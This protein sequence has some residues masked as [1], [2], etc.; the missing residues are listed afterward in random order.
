M[1]LQ[2]GYTYNTRR[3]TSS[4][5]LIATAALPATA[6][7]SAPSL[8]SKMASST[9]ERPFQL[10]H[11]VASKTYLDSPIRTLCE[12]VKDPGA[13]FISIHDLMEAYNILSTRIRTILNQDTCI[14]GL[15]IPSLAGIAEFSSEIMHCI[16]RDIQR[17]LPSPF[18]SQP[19][20]D[21]SSY[22]YYDAS[23]DLGDI[24]MTTDNI[25]LC[26]YAL[27]FASD[28]FAFSMLYSIFS[29]DV[30]IS[31]LRGALSLCTTTCSPMVNLDKARAMVVWMLKTQQLPTPILF[32]LK[33]DIFATVKYAMNCSTD[34]STIKVDA[35][36]AIYALTKEHPILADSLVDLLDPLLVYLTSK[37]LD[38]RIH[39]SLALCGFAIAKLKSEDGSSYPRTKTTTIACEYI[40]RETKRSKILDPNQ[41]LPNILK[42]ALAG[43]EFW[44]EY[45]PS[46]S[47]AVV[48]SFI[49]LI[50]RFIWKT[51]RSLKLLVNTIALFAGHRRS[52][53]RKAHPEL[54]RMLI[55]AF[56]RLPAGT[57]PSNS[58][59]SGDADSLQSVRDS[60]YNFLL[61]E[62]KHGLLINVVGSLLSPCNGE[63][64]SHVDVKKAVGNVL[65]LIT[66]DDVPPRDDGMKLLGRM[67]VDI[68]RPPHS[69]GEGE[70]DQSPT[71][72][73]SW[74]LIDGSAAN[75]IA[76][77]LR[78]LPFKL[79]F[80]QIPP[81]T[82]EEIVAHWD[83]LYALWAAAARKYR[84]REPE[85][86]ILAA[87]LAAW[88][89]LLLARGE[90][91]P[92]QHHFSASPAVTAGISSIL[93]ELASAASPDTTPGAH[94][95]G[96]AFVRKLWGVTRNVFTSDWLAGLAQMLLVALLEQSVGGADASGDES[97]GA[98]CTELVATGAPGV[99]H[100]LE[101]RAVTDAGRD[102]ARRLWLA[103]ARG[104]HF[105]GKGVECGD[106]LQFLAIPIGAWDMSPVEFEVWE[107]V[108]DSAGKIS[109][110]DERDVVSQLVTMLP[111]AKRESLTA[112]LRT[113]YA[114][115]S[116]SF[117]ASASQIDQRLLVLVDA[118]LRRCYPAMNSD[119][120]E[121]EAER[122]EDVLRLL[123]ALGA[124]LVTTTPAEVVSFLSTMQDSLTCWVADEREILQ[125]DLHDEIVASLYKGPLALLSQVEPSI[126][127]LVKIADF[128]AAVFRHIRGDGALAF[129]A[130]WRATYHA[131]ADIPKDAYPASI[132]AC[133]RAWSIFCDDSLGDGVVESQSQ[134]QS[135]GDSTVPGSQL[136]ESMVF[137]DEAYIQE[138][139]AIFAAE[140]AAAAG[141]HPSPR[142]VSLPQLGSAQT[143][144]TSVKDSDAID[145]FDD[146]SSRYNANDVQDI[147]TGSQVPLQE[148]SATSSK[149]PSQDS[150]TPPNAKRRR[151]DA[152][153]T[154]F[155]S[156]T[157]KERRREAPPSSS[158]KSAASMLLS[159][160]SE[161]ASRAASPRARQ[162]ASQPSQAIRGCDT[163]GKASWLAD[164]TDLSGHRS[165]VEDEHG[166]RALRTSD[167]EMRSS[168][169]FDTWEQ[170]ISAED[171]RDVRGEEGEDSDFFAPDSEENHPGPASGHDAS[172]DDVLESLSLGQYP[173]RSRI[174]Y[175]SQTAPEPGDTMDVATDMR[176][177]HPLRREQTSPGP[178]RGATT[179]AA[180]LDALRNAYAAL[181]DTEGMSQDDV[182]EILQAR[183]LARRIDQVLDERIFSKITSSASRPRTP[184]E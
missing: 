181:A 122:K 166:S 22:V 147:G 127:T 35:L 170:G 48:A 101:V 10:S 44:A 105:G 144:D 123:R 46:F 93:V 163:G 153:H 84:Q 141:V 157:G 113:L 64:R 115:L 71:I 50:D 60:A 5:L 78:V 98:L 94:A 177:S 74:S 104:G 53:I 36:A 54:W 43:E 70:G 25:S 161:P 27:R 58:Q 138:Y 67:L 174:R 178:Q 158:H 142:D 7:L 143:Y 176:P 155:T 135:V 114:L 51:P 8:A 34:S 33:P 73:F 17:T 90:V 42:S 11:S 61:Q 118:G 37:S 15:P 69:R 139:E 108:L 132:K 160:V 76:K 63:L 52:N 120:R 124:V 106:V 3:E 152:P 88:Q 137:G 92:D 45:G 83:E 111:D 14:T 40:D 59:E 97:W 184:G 109:E 39:A 65:D 182:E 133:L 79:D 2:D 167:V 24:Q 107:A 31:L 162:P 116:R 145:V 38:L 117:T 110:K 130:F 4:L 180:P 165:I 100:E 91:V 85:H 129:D 171:L 169:D 55:W 28:I 179:L 103:V 159:S 6:H 121:H 119:S 49:V 26:H 82:E 134:S 140:I 173:T 112:D 80:Q 20:Q 164:G 56:S 62:R 96:L 72:S 150:L 75:T 9:S 168:D 151:I 99:L 41:R 13:L 102:A 19:Q 12:S 86:E 128:V 89:T 77:E 131:R 18:D 148:E 183:H 21:S 47:L 30:L 172:D 81:L 87:L 154:P 29:D 149:R 125:D 32:A 146:R 57:Q 95:R 175:R 23:P 136:A 16:S 68:G 1:I 156:R 126:A 66:S